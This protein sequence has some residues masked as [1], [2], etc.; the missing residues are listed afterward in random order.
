MEVKPKKTRASKTSSIQ[1]EYL[2]G[3]MQSHNAFATGKL[4]GARGKAAHDTQWQELAE[5]LNRLEGP[6]KSVEAWKKLWCDQRNQARGRAAKVK[7]DQ[8]FTGNT[9]NAIQLKDLDLRILS[10]IGG[11]SSVSLP[12][13][14]MGFGE[15]PE[16][17]ADPSLTLG[18]ISS[19]DLNE[20][21]IIQEEPNAT[22]TTEESTSAVI[23]DVEETILTPKPQENLY[24]NCSRIVL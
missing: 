23:Q 1:L 5:E 11:E 6:S 19:T 8:K 21:I 7:A 9:G 4:L 12:V 18:L 17:I 20:F 22:E 2:I 14:E 3:Y 13:M 15:R 24:R 16:D 10:V